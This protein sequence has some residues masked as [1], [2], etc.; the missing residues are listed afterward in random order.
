MM[1]I[2]TAPRAKLSARTLVDNMNLRAA[3]VAPHY[4][5]LAGTLQEYADADFGLEEAAW[6]VRKNEL[7]S[8][9]GFGSASTD[10]PFAFSNGVAIIPIHGTL[11][12]RFSYSWGFVTGYNFVRSQ[13]NAA[14][15]DDDVELIVF[16]CNSNGGM[17]AG[18]F[19]LADE[20]HA[21]RAKK[22]SL[23]VVD[24]NAYSAGYALASSATKVAAI[25]SAGVGSIGVVAMHIN[26]GEMLKEAGIEITFIHAG[27]HKVDGNPFEALSDDVKANIQAGVD[28]SYQKFVGLVARNRNLSTDTVKG[29]EARCY[30]ADD[31]LGL[32]LIDAMQSPSEAVAAYLDELSGSTQQEFNMTTTKTEPGAKTEQPDNAAVAADARKAERERMAGILNCEEAKGKSKLA[33]HLAMNTEMSVDEAKVLLSHAAPEQAAAAA[34]AKGADGNPFQKHMDADQH[35]EVGADPSP[36]AEG[37]KP[38][39]SAE[40]LAAQRRATGRKPATAA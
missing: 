15:E 27:K 20:I 24:S 33:N 26:V 36:S 5:G 17:A 4:N 23:A 39:R 40:I 34:P 28:K 9:Y 14:V 6:E 29:T 12:N 38:S 25:P 37:S 21:S 7:C 13:L 35:P 8:A 10:K 1:P 16:D 18:C 22:P 31:A 32:G 19:E 2:A 11:L 30:D 3:L